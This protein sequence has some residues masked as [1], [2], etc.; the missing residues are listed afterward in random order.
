MVRQ[1]AYRRRRQRRISGKV[2]NKNCGTKHAALQLRGAVQAAQQYGHVRA[3]CAVCCYSRKALVQNSGERI[4]NHKQALRRGGSAVRAFTPNRLVARATLR[5]CG[6]KG[7]GNH[8]QVYV[9]G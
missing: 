4:K 7:G 8:G 9:W 6:A 2:H 3:V 1:R 5:C